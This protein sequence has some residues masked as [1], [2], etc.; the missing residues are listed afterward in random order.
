[1]EILQLGLKGLLPTL[2]KTNGL[3]RTQYECVPTNLKLANFRCLKPASSNS[4][5]RI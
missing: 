4:A 3:A 1:M 2:D 5:S